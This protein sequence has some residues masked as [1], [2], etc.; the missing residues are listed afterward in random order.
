MGRRSV[1]LAALALVVAGVGTACGED[2]GG[3]GSGRTVVATTT[4]LAD[5]ARQVGGRRIEVE[6]ILEPGSDP[7]AYEPRLSDA[8]AVAGAVVV[9]RSGGEVDEWLDDLLDDAGADAIVS[10]VG[11]HVRRS[12]KDPHWWQ[13]PRNAV[14]AV[15]SIRDALAEGDRGGR[16][17]YAAN[18]AGYIRRLRALDR[19]V[20]GCIAKVPPAGRRLV[21]THDALGYFADR[22]RLHLVGAVIPSLSTQAQPSARDI[23]RLAEQIRRERVRAI[24]TEPARATKLERALARESGARLGGDLW[25]DALGPSGSDGETY[26]ESIVS[27]AE[28]IVAGLSGR[29]VTCRPRSM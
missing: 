19:S 18:A 20:A 22:Y 1:T 10:D 24:F 14:L 13:D 28:T 15:E 27:N 29:R 6:Q 9:L 3:G 7:H 25:T 26:V 12:G 2:K 17:T 23:G 16:R 4:Q 11:D 21:T 5:F 8:T